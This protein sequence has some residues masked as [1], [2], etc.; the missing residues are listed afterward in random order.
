VS[1]PLEA[2]LAQIPDGPMKDA[3][4]AQEPDFAEEMLLAYLEG[5]EAEQADIR[6]FFD[7]NG[8]AKVEECKQEI[9]RDEDGT[10]TARDLE[11]WVQ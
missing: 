5:D 4:R 10:P 7:S 11:G 3:L 6:A 9:L 2:L 8:P 1:E